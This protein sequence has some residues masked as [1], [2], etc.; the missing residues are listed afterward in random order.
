MDLW[1]A[2]RGEIVLIKPVASGGRGHARGGE[3]VGEEVVPL[4]GA[5][6]DFYHLIDV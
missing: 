5:S 2:E 6:V 4:E 1:L 3:D